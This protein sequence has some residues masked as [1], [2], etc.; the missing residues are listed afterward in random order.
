MGL[1]VNGTLEVFNFMEHL[2]L[3]GNFPKINLPAA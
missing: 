2:F 1:F 3:S